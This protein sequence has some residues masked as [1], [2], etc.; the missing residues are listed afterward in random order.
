MRRKVGDSF[1]RNICSPAHHVT[2]PPLYPQLSDTEKECHANLHQCEFNYEEVK[3]KL[4]TMWENYNSTVMEVRRLRNKL[5]DVE[6]SGKLISGLATPVC[7]FGA[8]IIIL[9]VC[10]CL[11]QNSEGRLGFGS[12]VRA[13][14][15]VCSAVYNICTTIIVPDCHYE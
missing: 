4:K 15:Q 13:L 7:L 12:V 9:V 1:T 2:L 11:Y 14:T 3:R 5:R 6:S 8:L 10:V